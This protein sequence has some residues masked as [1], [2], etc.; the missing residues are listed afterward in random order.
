MQIRYLHGYRSYQLNRIRVSPEDAQAKKRW[1]ALKRFEAGMGQGL[2]SYASAQIVGIPRSTL[3]R[4]KKRMGRNLLDLMDQSKRPKRLRQGKDKSVLSKRIIELREQYPTFG[5]LKIWK[6]LEREGTCVSQSMVGRIISKLLKDHLI[7]SGKWKDRQV[8][9]RLHKKRPYAQKLK[10]GKRLEGTRPG[11]VLQIDH[12][13]VSLPFGRTVKHFNAVCC[14]SRFSIAEAYCSASAQTAEAFIQKVISNMPFK[15]KS[16]Q[17]DGGSEFMAEFE[18]TCQK[19]GIAL[20]VLYPK[21]PQLNGH[22]ERL[23]GTWRTDFY[24]TVELPCNLEELR[25]LI[26]DYNDT[27][28][29]DRPHQ[30]LGLQTPQ[31][32][33]QNNNLWIDPSQ[34]HMY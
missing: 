26:Q 20:S 8:L 21:S 32:Y 22:V 15:I 6:L 18:R 4:W 30:S 24:Q 1:D 23:N 33:L 27:Y 9:K 11:E 5:K 14:H 25:P 12:M 28:N 17:V 2:S 34:S 19:F 10:R 16:I 13:S 7:L 29:W 3:Y 31:E